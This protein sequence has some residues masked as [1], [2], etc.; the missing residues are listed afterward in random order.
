MLDVAP[1]QR[2]VLALAREL[3]GFVAYQ[4]DSRVTI[5]VPSAKFEQAVE[6][7]GALGDLLH[8]NVRALDV[9]EEFRDVSVRLRNAEAVRAQLETLLAKAQNVEE[10][11][12]VQ[13]ELAKVTESIERFKGRLRFLE[14]RIAYS[15]I[16]VRFQPR[17]REH[18]TREDPFRLP[19][20][21]LQDVGLGRLLDLGY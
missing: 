13:R 10:A 17:P 2:R 18:L 19:F 9:T 6:G 8:R 11:L 7:V 4:D 16:D 20:G 15:T 1:Q 12:E 21:W 14:D 3:G 5:R